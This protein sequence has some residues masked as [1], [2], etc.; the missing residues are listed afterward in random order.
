MGLENS[1]RWSADLCVLSFKNETCF[2]ALPCAL[3]GPQPRQCKLLG[4]L[5]R[6]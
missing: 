1:S 5:P 3:P 6:H 4:G 2:G